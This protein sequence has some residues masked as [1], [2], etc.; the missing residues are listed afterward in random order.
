MH[1]KYRYILLFRNEPTIFNIEYIDKIYFS[2]Y[3]TLISIYK[4]YIYLANIKKSTLKTKS[5]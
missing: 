1:Y 5:A 4:S 3:T 2:K